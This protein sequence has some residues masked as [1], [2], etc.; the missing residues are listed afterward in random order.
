MLVTRMFVTTDAHGKE[1]RVSVKNSHSRIEAERKGHLLRAS[2]PLWL[3]SLYLLCPLCALAA[4]Q[5]P[6]P[7][8]RPGQPVRPAPPVAPAPA[9]PPTAAAPSTPEGPP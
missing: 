6:Q 3:I 8:P 7:F 9:P 2:L 1:P 5:Q 4:A